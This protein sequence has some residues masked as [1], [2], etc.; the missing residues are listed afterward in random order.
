[1]FQYEIATPVTLARR[2]SAMLPIVNESVKG[3][4][5]SIYNQQVQAKHPLNGLKLTN[6]TTLHLM[7]GPITVFDG[8]NYAGDAQ[9]DDVQPGAERLISYAMDLDTEVAP[10]SIGHPEQLI[11]VRIVKGT[12]YAARKFT[13]TQKYTVKNSGSHDKDVLIEYPF[14]ANWT[15]VAPKEPAEK[16]RNMYRFVVKAEP[17]KPA[18][19]SVDEERTD[20]Q[21][22]AVTNLDNG[23]I[24]FYA[25]TKVTTPKVKAALDEIIKRKEAIEQLAQK[26]QQLEQ[27]VRVIDRIKPGFARTCTSST[28]R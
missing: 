11:S 5:V 18:V 20:Q 16:T 14:D 25:N 28:T 8:G 17:G 3:K 2:Q 24:T 1:M 26:R 9:I 4:K 27:Q 21:Q 7:Q 19:L 6:S 22:F 15:L 12:L 13:R 10:E 23:T